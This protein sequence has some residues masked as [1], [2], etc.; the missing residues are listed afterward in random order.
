MTVQITNDQTTDEGAA[1]VLADV[2][3][4]FDSGRTRS[5]TWRSEQLRAIERLCDEREP[6]IAAALASDLGRSAVRGVARRHR[7]DQG[8]SGFRPQAPE[9]V[10]EPRKLRYRWRSYPDGPGCSTTRWAWCW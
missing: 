9:E 6:E 7:V 10:D 2:R 3:R 5:L 1:G 4:V 8:R